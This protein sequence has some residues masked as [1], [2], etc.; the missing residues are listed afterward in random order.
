MGTLKHMLKLAVKE[1]KI[2]SNPIAEL[3][4]LPHDK[5][6]KERRAL[7]VEEIEAI[8]EASPD[9]LRPVWRMFVSSGVRKNELANLTFDDVDFER[10][11]VTVRAEHAKNRKPREIPLDNEMLAIIAD[12]RDQAERR[13]PVK[14][15]TAKLTIQQRAA[16]SKD[17][18]FV[19]QANTPLR[20]NLLRRFYSVC[21]KARIEGAHFGGSVDLHSLRVTFATI[22]L[23]NGASPKAVQALLGHSTLELT[24]DIYARATDRAKRNAIGALPFADV[25]SPE[26]VISMQP[27]H[28]ART[29]KKGDTQP[30]QPKRLA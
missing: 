11:S 9:C 15:T 5:L 10:R 26:G 22:A 6:A 1:G 4:P 29:S 19:S 12:L 25:S 27:A 8:L 3:N 17:H 20:N 28:T 23:E 13:E 16:F 30:V 2:G 18:I 7:S 14:G 21:K 24:M